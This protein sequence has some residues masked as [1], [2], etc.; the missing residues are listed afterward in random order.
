MPRKTKKEKEVNSSSELD[1]NSDHKPKT[2]KKNGTEVCS[3]ISLSFHF[4]VVNLGASQSK[5]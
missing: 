3:N 5:R 2:T 1:D 4:N